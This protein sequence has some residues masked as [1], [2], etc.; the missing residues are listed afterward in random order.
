VAAVAQVR[1]ALEDLVLRAPFSGTVVEVSAR[2]GEVAAQGLPFVPDI[3]LFA[4]F[5]GDGDADCFGGVT[6]EPEKPTR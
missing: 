2:L 3:V 6:C 5:D 4:D 1:G